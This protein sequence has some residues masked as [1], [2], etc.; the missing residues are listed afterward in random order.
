MDTVCRYP[1][2]SLPA[3]VAMPPT[4]ARYSMRLMCLVRAVVAP[5]KDHRACASTAL[6]VLDIIGNRSRP[7][8]FDA[9]ALNVKMRDRTA[10]A[11]DV[12]VA[13]RRALTHKLTK[14]AMSLSAQSTV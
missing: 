5:E 10:Y 1:F 6:M 7:E 8:A 2:L 4:S 11:R 14:A 3:S 12:E 9:F 13:H